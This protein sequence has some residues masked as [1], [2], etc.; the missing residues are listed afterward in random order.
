MPG[1]VLRNIQGTDEIREKQTER[2]VGWVKEIEGSDEIGNMYINM[3]VCFHMYMH[4]YISM[5]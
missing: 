2:R 1:G 5:Y 3:C 4:T